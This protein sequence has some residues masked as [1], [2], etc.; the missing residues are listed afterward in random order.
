[1]GRFDDD[2][3]LIAHEMEHVIEQLD[4]IDLPSLADLPDTGVHHTL[5]A[6]VTFETSRA[7]QTGLRVAREVRES[8]Q[9]D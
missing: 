7:A 1:M 9:G 4:E 6:G 2:V 8:R 5:S 3:E